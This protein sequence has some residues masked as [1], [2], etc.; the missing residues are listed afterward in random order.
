MSSVAVMT[1]GKRL[2]ERSMKQ[3]RSSDHNTLL[4]MS[5]LEREKVGCSTQGDA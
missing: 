3:T 2:V 4:I 5:E 1:F